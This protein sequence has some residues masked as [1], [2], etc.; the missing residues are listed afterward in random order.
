[1]VA[2]ATTLGILAVAA[3]AGGVIS[4]NLSNGAGTAFE[5]GKWL[6]QL[7]TVF[8]GAGLIT[9][10]LRMVDIA[11]TKRE[12]WTGLLQDVIAASNTV[13]VARLNLVGNASAETYTELIQRCRD[14]RATLRRIIAAPDLHDQPDLRS[15]LQRMRRYLLPLVLEYE[16]NY[17]QI[18]R[19]QQLDEE[20][21]SYQLKKLS[22]KDDLG[23]LPMLPEVLSTPLQ[24][25]NMISDPAV[26]P[27]LAK[28]LAEYKE[29]DFRK[30]Y[31]TA[32]SILEKNAGVRR[33]HEGTAV[34]RASGA[35]ERV[36]TKPY[37]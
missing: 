36:D 13:D 14:V 1:M 10:V 17:L 23:E 25:A 29:G 19:Q 15:A 22:A 6:L 32:K 26:L 20:I 27:V 24:A 34:Q 21:V 9:A 7:A 5:V 3:V 28:S 12:S 35:R 31:V 8:V 4:L 30:A 33:Q 18:S 16:S 11:R 37:Q 2:L